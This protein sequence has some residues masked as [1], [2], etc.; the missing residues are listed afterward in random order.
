VLVRISQE[1]GERKRQVQRATEASYAEA[2]R[3]IEKGFKLGKQADDLALA[4]HIITTLMMREAGKIAMSVFF[5]NY[6]EVRKFFDKKV[7]SHPFQLIAEIENYG[8]SHNIAAAIMCQAAPNLADAYLA[9]LFCDVPV[10]LRNDDEKDL[11][12]LASFCRSM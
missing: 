8:I 6:L 7:V 2:I 4:K 1:L 5:E 9:T 11:Q 3:R 10:R 12:A